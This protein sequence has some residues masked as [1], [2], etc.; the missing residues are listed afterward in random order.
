MKRYIHFVDNNNSNTNE[1][2]VKLR[3][4]YDTSNKVLQQSGFFSHLFY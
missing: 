3:K 2:F 4:L 1:K